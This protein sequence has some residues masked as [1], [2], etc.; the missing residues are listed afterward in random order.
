M[1]LRLS[2][3][4]DVPEIMTI[5]EKARAFLKASGVD[6]WQTGYPDEALIRGDIAAG[7]GYVLVDGETIAATLSIDCSGE[8]AYDAI[9]EGA[10][11]STNLPYGVVHRMAVSPAHRGKGVSKIVIAQVEVLL[12]KKS[13]GS[14]KID[15]HRDN[16]VMNH[17]LTGC[18]FSYCGIVYFEGAQRLAYEKLL[19]KD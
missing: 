15:T 18:G 19:T 1:K 17:L 6:Q 14:F 7:I 10:W 9:E 3:V 5:I 4:Q 13:M 16:P 8:P 2:T 11:L 12:A